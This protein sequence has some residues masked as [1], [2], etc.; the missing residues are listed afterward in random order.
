GVQPRMED[1]GGAALLPAAP[2]LDGGPPGRALRRI[3]EDAREAH[4]PAQFGEGRRLRPPGL[5]LVD[6]APAL[7]AARAVP[8][9]PGDGRRS[10]PDPG[11]RLRLQPNPADAP[12]GGRSRHASPEAPSAAIWWSPG[13]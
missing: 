12:P 1:P 7:L 5:R 9:D 2:R 10:H 8:G 11:H 13:R 3:R 6:P 4:R